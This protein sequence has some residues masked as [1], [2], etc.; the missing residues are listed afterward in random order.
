MARHSVLQTFYASKKWRSFR[1]AL[2]AERGNLCQRCNRIIVK[3]HEII[4]HH[5][6]ELTPTSVED[7]SISLN[8]E[9]V[10]LLC[11]DCHDQVH[12]RFGYQK[13]K[14]V[15]LVYGSPLSGKS[16]YVKQQMRR[17]DLIVDIDRLYGALSG[18]PIYDKP[19]H[20]LS[21]VLG[22][23]NHLL[24]NLKTRYGRWRNGWV[25]GGYANKQKRERLADELGAELVYCTATKEECLARLQMDEG[26]RGH[27]EEWK[28]YI[29]KWFDDF[30]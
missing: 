16:T 30:V 7:Y 6:T 1:L 19:D 14:K 8:P 25:V 17:G 15:Y 13:Q 4:G 3:A 27:K 10:L 28:R 18:L 24:D 9:Q 22:V 26:R 2:I 12:E 11:R 20:L 23:H 21:I 29:Q 5:R